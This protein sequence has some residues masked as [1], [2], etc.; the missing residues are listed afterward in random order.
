MLFAKIEIEISNDF[1]ESNPIR[2]ST[3]I[4]LKYKE[5]RN[6]EDRIEKRVNRRR[7]IYIAGTCIIRI[8]RV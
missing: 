1:S 8:Q 4:E 7:C 3:S 5:L 2:E 6:R